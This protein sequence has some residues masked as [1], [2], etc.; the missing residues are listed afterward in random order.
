MSRY[1]KAIAALLGGL[2]PAVVCGILALVHVHIDPTVAAG[3]CTVLAT[4]A[5]II[6]PAN[7]PAKPP[8]APTT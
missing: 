5:T 4:V 7:A 8:A 1:A 3:I 6:A 2:T